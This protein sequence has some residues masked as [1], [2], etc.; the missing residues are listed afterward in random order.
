MNTYLTTYADYPIGRWLAAFTISLV[1]LALAYAQAPDPA[2]LLGLDAPSAPTLT[3]SHP[4]L[5]QQRGQHLAADQ[6]PSLAT[7]QLRQPTGTPPR[8]QFAR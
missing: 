3:N 6:A 8:S 7:A 4:M 2:G 1:L 5:G